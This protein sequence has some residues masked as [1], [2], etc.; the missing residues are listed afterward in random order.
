M[1]MDPIEIMAPP[2]R[3]IFNWIHQHTTWRVFFHSCGSIYKII[4]DLIDIGVDIL[5]PVQ[6]GAARMDPLRLKR[7]FGN[8]LC[9]WGGVFDVQRM[10]FL[11]A[12]EVKI[13]VREHIAAFAPGGGFV[14]GGTHNIQAG[15]PVENIVAAYDTAHE[16]GAYPKGE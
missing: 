9:F 16:Y 3:R 11:T 6:T 10:P 12:D 15:T 1:L 5:N 4:P 8:R 2:Y 7:E 14:F 13:E